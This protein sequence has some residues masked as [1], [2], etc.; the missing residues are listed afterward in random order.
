ML[1]LCLMLMIALFSVIF[2]TLAGLVITGEVDIGILALI[3]LHI[4][5]YAIIIPLIL[6]ERRKMIDQALP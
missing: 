4:V 5:V 2:L 3:A 1:G 6:R